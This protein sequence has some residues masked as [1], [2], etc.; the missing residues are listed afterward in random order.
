[1]YMLTHRLDTLMSRTEPNAVAPKNTLE[2]IKGKILV[3]GL[4][5]A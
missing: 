3:V 1:M 2:I 4:S 5:S